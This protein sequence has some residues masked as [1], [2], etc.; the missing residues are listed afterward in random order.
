VGSA[1]EACALLG[2]LRLAG[3]PLARVGRSDVPWKA[4]LLA[5]T[6]AVQR[7]LE[8]ARRQG[9]AEAGAAL[10]EARAEVAALKAAAGAGTAGGGAGAAKPAECLA[11]AS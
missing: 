6:A 9:A 11:G 3:G 4:P 8:V 2:E 1:L 10:V 7:M 5:T